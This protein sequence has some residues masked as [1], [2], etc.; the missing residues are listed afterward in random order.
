MF[1]F[2]FPIMLNLLWV[3]PA[4]VL[5]L[6]W[7]NLRERR[8]MQQFFSERLARTL[9]GQNSPAKRQL[10]RIAI[11]AA[12]AIM[13]VGLARPQVALMRTEVSTEGL[14][15]MFLIDTSRSMTVRDVSGGTRLERAKRTLFYLVDQ[16]SEHRIGLL[17]FAGNAFLNCPTTRDTG[18]L[19]LLINGLD[20]ST[21][22]VQGTDLGNALEEA[23]AAF[24]RTGAQHRA[25]VVISDGENFGRAPL[26]KVKEASKE[27]IRT[28]CLGVGS[29]EGAPMPPRWEVSKK[30]PAQAKSS[31]KQIT[32]LD[33]IILKKMAL[34]GGGTYARLSPGGKEADVLVA[35]LNKLEKIEMFSERHQTWEDYYPVAALLALLFLLF[36]LLI[37]RR[38]GRPRL[39]NLIRLFKRTGAAILVSVCLASLAQA[40]AQKEIKQ[41]LDAF[42]RQ[43]LIAAERH[44]NE[45]RQA[46]AGDALAEYNLGCAQLGQHKYSQAYKAFIRALPSA[47]GALEQDNWYNFGYTAFYLG[48]K[49]G[50]AEKWQEAVDAFKKCLLLD[51]QDDDAR[52]NLELIL[53]EIKK[54]TKTLSKREEQS[55]GTDKGKA[56]GSGADKPG[57][58]RQSSSGRR[59]DDAPPNEEQEKTSQRKEQKGKTSTSD[60]QP[61]RKQKGMSQEDAL[62]ALRSLEAEEST[63]QKNSPKDDKQMNEYKGPD[64]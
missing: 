21:L 38:K 43:D 7:A 37:G 27:G 25:I 44:F 26:P 30:R 52:Y 36:E 23:L 54:R 33:E 6:V 12:I 19:K 16:L 51:P 13:I 22:P 48:I 55:Q 10:G 57:S 3:L 35:E 50:K 41:G 53:R 62:R 14:D 5:G 11:I 49:Q 31:S 4:L 2:A 20:T 32:R 40:A 24:Q 17:P 59:N 8:R 1:R 45:A 9:T 60:Q 29:A 61:G 34:V 15:I 18:A 42:K 63:V 47:S 64:W 58:D 56:P 46:N 39:A 28:Y